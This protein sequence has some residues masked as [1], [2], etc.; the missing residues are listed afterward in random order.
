MLQ[1]QKSFVCSSVSAKQESPVKLGKK[2]KLEQ[3]ISEIL[4]LSGAVKLPGVGK[5]LT[6]VDNLT[7][8]RALP[9]RSDRCGN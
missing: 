3:G 7:G 1:A 6:L 8:P 5:Q 4:N 2:G 9:D